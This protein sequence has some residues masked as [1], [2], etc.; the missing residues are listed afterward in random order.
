M[1]IFDPLLAL[2]L[3][4]ILGIIN[5]VTGTLI[6]FSCRCFPGSKLGNKLKK[7][8][9]Y[10]SFFKYHCHIWKVFWPSVMIHAILVIIFF[11]W[12]G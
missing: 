2:R 10:Q 8:Q 9:A 12:P 11:G 5:L 6:F 3:I 7:Y 1:N 4:I